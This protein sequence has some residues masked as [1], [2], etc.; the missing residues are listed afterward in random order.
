MRAHIS[1]SPLWVILDVTFGFDMEDRREER[2]VRA[3]ERIADALEQL[4]GKPG[5][6]ASPG[7]TA[8]DEPGQL[9]QE[10]SG[11]PNAAEEA[12]R[13][14][15]EEF[16]LTQ[17]IKIKTVPPPTAADES[18][19]Q[20]AWFLGKRYADLSGLLK[21]MKRTMQSGRGFQYQMAGLPQS[22]VASSCQFCVQ[23]HELAFLTQYNY[24]RSPKYIIYASP[25]TAPA[26]QKFLG[27]HWL[28]RY[29]AKSLREAY[30]EKLH[31]LMNPQ[32]VMPNGDDFELDVLAVDESMRPLWIEAK[33]GDYQSHVAK[34][35]KAAK[36]L[37]VPASR[38]IMIL[39]DVPDDK[40]LALSGL[41]NM[42]VVNMPLWDA[43]LERLAAQSD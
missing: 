31:L 28:E 27:G 18:I 35:S 9:T 32:I 24:Q 34:Y 12:P 41:F 37:G 3:F 39:P 22:T 15:V 10:D 43:C 38:S 5:S 16:L 23:L 7:E 30:G 1:D 6:V 19:D 17:G 36:L 33:T 2:L 14:V 8:L 20:L 26:A 40:C 42:T 11:E 13:K 29:V 4:A 25:S 21:H